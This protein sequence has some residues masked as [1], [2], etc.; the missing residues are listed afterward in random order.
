MQKQAV[1]HNIIKRQNA[2]TVEYKINKQIKTVTIA[3]GSEDYGIAINL[4]PGDKFIFEMRDTFVK[5]TK[6]I[7]IEQQITPLPYIVRKVETR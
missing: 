5:P 6:T 1:C 3:C 2:V 4:K 7:E